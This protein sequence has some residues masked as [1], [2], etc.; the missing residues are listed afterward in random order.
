MK[1]PLVLA[2][3]IA[4]LALSSGLAAGP[5]PANAA[6]AA[7]KIAIVTNLGTIEA[8]L[9][10][11][12]APITVKNFLH[13]V[14]AKFFDDGS[15]FRAIPEFVIQG[16]NKPREKDSDTLIPLETPMKTGLR[17]VDGALS[18]ART[19]DPNSA[20]SEFFIDDG[21]QARLD[22]SMTEPG[23]AVFGHVTKNMELVRQIARLPAQG[24]M[25][26]TPVKIV[27]I[28]RLP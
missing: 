19:S 14:D 22:G 6:P 10:P 1:R 8:V 23:Y 12:H 4:T 2:A 24:Q 9:D 27:R 11:V 7:V 17:N 21:A 13:Y 5:L 18:M 25:L 16:G 20:T 28:R 26:L 3:L 15:F